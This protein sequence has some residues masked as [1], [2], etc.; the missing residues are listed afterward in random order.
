MSARQAPANHPASHKTHAAPRH[1]IRSRRWWPWAKRLAYL[2]FLALVTWLIVSQAQLVDWDD[3][4][5][6]MRRRTAAESAGAVLLA[7]AS[8]ALYSCFDLLGRRY[9]GHTLATRQVVTV[10]FISYAFNLNLG[11]MIGA[12]A[13]RYRLYSRLG[14]DL[15]VITRVLLLAML[16]NW[17]GYVLLA[18]AVLCWWPPPLPDEWPVGPGLLPVLGGAL[19]LVPAVYLVLCIRLPGRSW[20]VRGHDIVLPSWRLAAL[21]L[22]MSCA[23]WLLIA[24]VITVLLQNQIPFPTVLGTFLLAAVAG[25]ITHVPGGLGV[26]EATFLLLLSDRLPH[27]ELL[28]ALLSFRVIYYF[29]PLLAAGVVYL[30]FELR[31]RSGKPAH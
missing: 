16:T 12:A 27:S 2:L 1:G 25:V 29:A 18:G 10:N 26:L 24:A 11:S 20:S 6:A 19:L 8:F 17:L 13:F 4:L 3:V 14:L 7:I 15:A 30:V 5:V 31:H 22:A 28:A 23:N 21:Q 9:T